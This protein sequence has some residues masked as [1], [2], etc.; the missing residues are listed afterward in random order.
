MGFAGRQSCRPI[1]TVD[2]VMDK[3]AQTLEEAVNQLASHWDNQL[4]P[5]LEYLSD[6]EYLWEPAEGCWSVRR[7]GE[8]NAPVQG[9]SGEYIVEFAFPEP[10]PPP[11]TTIAW[12]LAHLIVGVFGMRAANHFGAPPMDYF[13]HE[14]AGTAGAALAQLETTY[15]AWMSGLRTMPAERLWEP[16]CETEGPYAHVSY[17]GLILHINREAL[18]H[19][20]EIMLLRDLY[21]HRRPGS[22]VVT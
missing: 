8:S 15:D 1:S 20:A 10:S 22:R 18:H 6:D 19:G 3:S 16:V 17:L 21:L 13:T 7:R 9:G 11:V 4:R 2:R 5:R 14:F 12:R